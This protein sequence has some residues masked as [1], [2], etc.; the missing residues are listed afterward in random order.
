MAMKD[1]VLGLV[2]ERRS[3]GFELIRRFNERFGAAWQLN[4]STIYA[5]LDALCAEGSAIGRE[6]DPAGSQRGG[7]RRQRRVVYEATALGRERF[8]TWLTAPTAHVEP[9]RAE[10]F[11]KI[12][13][14][15]REHAY[16]LIQVIDAQIDACSEALARHLSDYRLD[17]ADGRAV[18]W[19]TASSWLVN[20][21]AATRLQAD[22]TWLKRVR[23]AA[24]A[25]RVH[26]AVPLEHLSSPS[27]TAALDAVACAARRAR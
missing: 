24:E 23:S 13:L 16:A 10:M 22:L 14:A 9:V 18:S 26:G 12:G 6:H 27:P 20:D 7:P 5:A 19:S 4:Q 25:L 2:V 11:L 3:Y 8:L 17:G 21:A 1:A 15:T